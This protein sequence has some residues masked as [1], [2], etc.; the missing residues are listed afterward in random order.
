[1]LWLYNLILVPTVVLLAPFALLAALCFPR[2]RRGLG[3]RLW[4]HVRMPEPSVWVHAASVGEVEAAAPLIGALLERGIPTCATTLT[5]SG[6]DRL[7]ARLPDLCVRLAPLDLP[8]LVSLA[9]TRARARVLVLVE[10]ELWPNLIHAVA[11]RGGR[12]VVVSGRLS[13]A[14]Y[15]HYCRARPL[16]ASVFRELSVLGARTKEDRERF[17]QLGVAPERGH[18]VGDLKLDRPAPPPPSDEL[19][20]AIGEGPFLVGG[21]THAGEEEALL[22]AWRE[23]R[24][25]VAPALRLVLVPRHPERVPG[26]L[27]ML[28][29][30][31]V[32]VGLRSEG[33]AKADV[34]L[35]DSIGELTSLYALAELVFVGG[36]L[37]PIGGHN[38]LEPVQAGKL[39]VHGP[40]I[41]NQRS[42]VR[43]LRPLGVLRR[44]ERDG[45]LGP[46]LGRLWADD[47]RAELGARG[48]A[49]LEAHRG[50]LGR[51][52]ELV[53]EARGRGA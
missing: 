35:V 52:L 21:S 33:A 48:R 4:P 29:R 9:V 12:V 24:E 28:R 6:R 17:L 32:S 47:E 10:T 41:E 37:A 34:V 8:G 13:D 18:V 30:E 25:R 14:S 53:L 26:L 16:L 1:M 19:R 42:Q 7:R 49:A 5:A 23:L 38:L 31:A 51:S 50:A 27:R 36:T 40:H 15:P 44:V 20:A 2:A 43:L 11:S 46:A 22:E 45:D 39:V 3:E